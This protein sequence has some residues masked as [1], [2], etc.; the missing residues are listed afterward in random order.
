MRISVIIPTYNRKN[1][2]RKLL[3]SLV[4]D[5]QIPEGVECE[6]IVADDRS[7]DG[8]AE[9][10]TTEF[11]SVRLVYGP[12]KDAELNKRAAVEVSTGDFL[13]NLDD[14]CIPRHGW[15]AKVVPDLLRGEKLVQCKIIFLD[16]GQ[17]EMQDESKE[18]FRSGYRWDGLP[19]LILYG[20]YRPQYLK[21]CHEF[22]LFAAREVL[23]KVPLDDPNLKF[24]HQGESASFYFRAKH[25]GY[26]VYFQPDAIIDHL[27]ADE[28]GCKERSEKVSP[29][30]NCNDF[31]TGMV[32]NMIV[33]NRKVNPGKLPIMI[34]YYL[35][36]SLYLSILQKKNCFKY[37]YRGIRDGLRKEFVPMRYYENLKVDD[38]RSR[39]I[40]PAQLNVQRQA[41]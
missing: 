2:L 31:T 29:K 9:M 17:K 10:V 38:D 14:D 12:G 23:A 41:A 21:S 30:K 35:V 19:E 5:T 39:T 13:V 32:H 34:T 26:K 11:P 16:H 4:S 37:F 15:I 27:G 20:G 1:I 18:H 28:G 7:K 33:L 25:E 22:G 8:T 6:I 24:N 3:A 36:G 40:K